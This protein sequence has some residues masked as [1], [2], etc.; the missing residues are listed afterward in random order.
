[1][2]PVETETLLACARVLAEGGNRVELGDDL[3]AGEGGVLSRFLTK[4]WSKVE[5]WGRWTDGRAASFH[6]LEDYPYQR[7]RYKD[8]LYPGRGYPRRPF[9]S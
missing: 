4:G 8:A 7:A 2:A 5:P 6:V 3:E 1:M 9:Q